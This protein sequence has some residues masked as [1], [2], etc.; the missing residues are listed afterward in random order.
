MILSKLRCVNLSTC[1]KLILFDLD[2]TIL[3]FDD[4]W[5][6]S[7]KETFRQYPITMDINT[8]QLFEVYRQK[9]KIYV[10]LY[11]QQKIT[12][13]EYRTFRFIQTLA[14][15]NKVADESTA[16][17]FERIYASI[18]KSFMKANPEL[19]NVLGQLTKVYQLG[20]VTNGTADI[21]Y[22]KINA[23]GI[24]PFFPNGTIFISE[25]IGYEKPS[26]QIYQKALN[27]FG[28]SPEEN[29]LMEHL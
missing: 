27:Y 14:E 17:S 2:D 8:D 3:H 12:I 19:L 26:P 9:E 10:D 5:E 6:D 25:E 11:H 23:I 4:Y 28:V 22:D 24:K 29:E 7:T 21:Q 1:Y 20:I 18:S 15:F 13:Y 16:T